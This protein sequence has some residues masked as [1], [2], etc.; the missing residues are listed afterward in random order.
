MLGRTEVFRKIKFD[1]GYVVN[2]WR[3]ESDFQL[4]AYEAGYKLVF[5]PHAVSFN[6]EIANDMGGVHHAARG[7]RRA[8]YVV[9]NNWRFIRK[10]RSTI[11]SK[12]N[13]G[14]IYVYISFF[15]LRRFKSEAFMPMLGQSKRYIFRA[16]GG[17]R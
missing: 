2:G 17:R 14:N 13:I 15:A 11:E 4:S 3:E 16:L 8:R 7:F 10:H 1:E 6:L 12:F 5:C 9:T